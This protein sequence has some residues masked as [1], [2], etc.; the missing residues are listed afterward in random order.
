MSGFVSV[1][2]YAIRRRPVLGLGVV[3]VA[4][5][6]ILTIWG[7]ALAPYDPEMA[8]PSAVLQPPS[9]E[10]WF[11]TDK[12]GMDV[13]SRVIAA[14]RTDIAIGVTATL[15]AL[16]I[17][18]PLG[19]I[20]GYYGGFVRE[21]VSRSADVLQSIPLFILA[22]ALVVMTGQ[23]ITNVIYA[24][25]FI[26]STIYV[27]LLRTQTYSLAQSQFIEA[28]KV[29]GSSDAVIIVRHILPLAIL[30]ALCQVSVNIGLAI[31]FTAGL[32]F[33]GAGVRIPTPEWGLMISVGAPDVMTGQWW[34][35][36]FPGL[37]IVLTVLGFSLFGD[38][39]DEIWNPQKR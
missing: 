13:F 19:V 14:P 35:T 11:G 7:H 6:L 25:A 20:S 22:M 3:M 29:V 37:A 9:R 24:I 38:L 1:A 26:N 33:V 28:A 16:F 4:V 30:P 18:A 15:L 12:S 8:D 27:R 21:I 34:T 17:G 5:S 31:L 2:W 32:S 39:L 23:N 10:H 36:V